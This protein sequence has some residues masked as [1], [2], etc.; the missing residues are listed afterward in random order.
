MY[1]AR[2]STISVLNNARSEICT[3]NAY[4]IDIKEAVGDGV[5]ATNEPRTPSEGAGEI[6][7]ILQ[8]AGT[9]LDTVSEVS[10]L[11]LHAG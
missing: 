3:L 6:L 9:I 10:P 2:T 1:S 7:Q 8:V 4:R 11:R 5:D